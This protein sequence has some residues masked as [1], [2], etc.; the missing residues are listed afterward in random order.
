MTNQP[1]QK[2]PWETAVDQGL[3]IISLIDDD[4]PEGAEYAADFFED[5]RAKVSSVIET[6]EQRRHVTDKQ[7]AAL[8]GWQI[9]IEAWVNRND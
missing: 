6:I 1:R 9:G 7:Q 8:D 3:E 5:V 2:Q 4:L